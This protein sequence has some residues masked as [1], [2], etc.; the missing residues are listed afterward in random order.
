MTK[1]G[2]HYSNSLTL[3]KSLKSTVHVKAFARKYRGP[4]PLPSTT[5]YLPNHMGNP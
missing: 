4:S 3:L 5:Q 1:G 2:S